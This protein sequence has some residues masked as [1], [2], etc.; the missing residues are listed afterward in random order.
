MYNQ[1]TEPR[2]AEAL[3]FM[4]ESK[5]PVI[6]QTYIPNEPFHQAYGRETADPTTLLFFPIFSEQGMKGDVIGSLT[7][8]IEWKFF[9]TS[10]YP[11][12]SED[13]DIVI[14]NSCNQTYTFRVGD[15]QT[16]GGQVSMDSAS[17]H[18]Q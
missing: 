5:L 15:F 14:S 7:Q 18:P 11:P 10:V 8:E 3:Q 17:R 1:Q 16:T 9:V 13:M 6:S 2:R 12:G 4:V